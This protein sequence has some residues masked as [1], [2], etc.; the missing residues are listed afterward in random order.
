MISSLG[1]TL[2]ELHVPL[3]MLATREFDSG[4]I[5][6]EEL[7]TRLEAADS[8]LREAVSMLLYEPANSPEGK[9]LRLAMDELRALRENIVDVKCRNEDQSYED[10]KRGHGRGRKTRK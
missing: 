3:V 2:Y 4:E 10:K 1:I 9:L 8:T 5:T 7:L 6:S